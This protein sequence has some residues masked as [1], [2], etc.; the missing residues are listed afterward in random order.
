MTVTATALRDETGRATSPSWLEKRVGTDFE[1]LP[2]L[3]DAMT[4]VARCLADGL[5]SLSAAPGEVTYKG[6]RTRKLDTQGPGGR[7]TVFALADA[8]GWSTPIGLQFDHRFI[9]VVVEACFGGGGDDPQL[10]NRDSLSP[11]ESSIAEAITEQVAQAITAGFATVLPTEVVLEPIRPKPD[12]TLLGKPGVPILA[13]TLVLHGIG[14]PAELEILIPQAALR[15]FRDRLA[16]GLDETDPVPDHQWSERLEAEVGRATMQVR[17]KHRLA[18]DDPWRH[19]PPS[20]RS[21]ARAADR[22]SQQ[23]LPG[24][25]RGRIV[26]LRTRPVGRLLHRADRGLRR[27]DLIT[28]AQA[29]PSRMRKERAQPSRV[30]VRICRQL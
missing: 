15:P 6:L 25:R 20:G 8:P 2:L 4:D 3:A 27:P 22:R 30:A 23:G 16:G 21:G 18:I 29:W 14:Q 11:I 12:L 1:R 26:P 5:A 28:F 9:S 19:R 13:A 24:M 7:G 10:T 17:G